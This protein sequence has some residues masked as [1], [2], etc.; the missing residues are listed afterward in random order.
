MENEN[1]K[2]N[3]K[4]EEINNN[5]IKNEEK[6]NNKS[7][8]N[9]IDYVNNIITISI[10]DFNEKYLEKKK[11]VTFYNIHVYNWYKDSEFTLSKRFSEFDDLYKNLSNLISNVPSI[12]KKTLFKVSAFEA[13]NKRRIEL[14]NFLKICIERKDIFNTKYF[15]EF[16]SLDK[17]APELNINNPTLEGELKEIPQ[18]VRDFLYLSSENIILMCCSDMNIISRTDSRISNFKFFWEKKSNIDEI[19]LGSV[20]CFKF[21]KL[22]IGFQFVKNWF[23][24]FPVQTGVIAFDEKYRN[25]GIGLDN[26][27]IYLLT[28]NEDFTDFKENLV[29]KYHKDRVMGLFF[30]NTTGKIYS[31]S[32]DK[33][34]YISDI[35]YSEKP[36]DVYKSNFGYTNLFNDT[37]NKRIFTTNEGG[38]IEIYLNNEIPPKLIHKVTTNNKGVIR[39][40]HINLKKQYLF[41]SDMN[42]NISVFSST[43]PGKETNISEIS[44]FG[45]SSKLRC[46]VYDNLNNYLITGDEEGR[47]TIWSLKNGCAIFVY[48]SNNKNA[49]T[50][51]FWD[52]DARYLWIGSKDKSIKI[53]RI[54]ERLFK[55]EIENFEKTKLK[56]INEKIAIKKLNE[57]YENE[58]D[59]EETNS[60]KD[61]LNGWNYKKD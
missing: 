7:I 2:N 39:G 51:M 36:I 33:H 22:G 29:L 23:K 6:N 18:G 12:P 25:F 26:G 52:E 24:T 10:P 43:L 54:P 35:N 13:L 27:E 19:P 37:L 15:F 61:D 44:N 16:L 31:V 48:N 20:F 34:F 45:N 5:E 50:K 14:E 42:G 56:E 46:L 30:D 57:K 32:T 53:L 17:F 55:E 60:D 21:A 11:A 9:N 58:S 49:I 40:L 3:N 28:A 59:S 1:D 47:I 8:L 38:E 4:I 41:T